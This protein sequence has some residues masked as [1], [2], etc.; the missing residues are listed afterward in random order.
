[1]KVIIK[2][3]DKTMAATA[4]HIDSAEKTLKKKHRERKV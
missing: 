1:M 2:F 4:T 3:C